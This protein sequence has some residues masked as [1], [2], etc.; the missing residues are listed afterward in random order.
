MPVEGRCCMS[1][2]INK[3]I[4]LICK[5]H[6]DKTKHTNTVHALQSYLSRITA[7]P[8][9]EIYLIDGAK[10]F[11]V[12]CAKEF[13]DQEILLETFTNTLENIAYSYE[14]ANKRFNVYE[15]ILECLIT[16]LHMLQVKESNGDWIVDLSDYNNIKRDEDWWNN[17]TP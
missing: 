17:E 12:D 8:G 4:L 7:L 13:L 10:Y 5:Q 16:S 11:L 15:G 3:D 6:F 2:T 9:P 1:R 14:I